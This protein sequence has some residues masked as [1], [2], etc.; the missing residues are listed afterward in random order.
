[1]PYKVAFAP[2]FGIFHLNLEEAGL[3]IAKCLWFR[4][5]LDINKTDTSSHA[6]NDPSLEKKLERVATH[7]AVILRQAI[8]DKRLVPSR[9][10]REIEG[11][12]IPEHTY[13]DALVLADWLEDCGI[14]LGETF[15][16]EYLH[17]EE[18]IAHKVALMVTAERHQSSDS[19][20]AQNAENI[21]LRKRIAELE[22]QLQDTQR[23]TPAHAPISE[24]QRGAYLNIIGSMVGLMLAKSPSGRPYS[25]FESQQAIIDAIHANFGEAPGLSERNL[26]GK[27]AEAK[28]TL[29]AYSS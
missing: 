28:R 4:G 29:T 11:L 22:Q 26:M 17:G 7:Y 9:I 20:P 3:L 21:F 8:T 5:E 16:E 1:M 23:Q 13:V 6:F 10:S 12:I 19:A 27:F 25:V 24:K 15:E 2:H 14:I 18:K